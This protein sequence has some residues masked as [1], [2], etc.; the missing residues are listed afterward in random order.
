MSSSTIL[1]AGL[2]NLPFPNTRHSVGHLIVDALASRF[3][4]TLDGH[5]GRSRIVLGD[6]SVDLTLFKPKPLM[7]VTGPAVATALRHTARVPSSLIVIHDSLQHKPMSLS[8]KFGGSANGHN[9]VKSVIRALGDNPNFHRFR[10]GIGRDGDAASYVL[11][12]LSPEEI[13]YW[14]LGA[15][16]DLI[17]EKLAAIALKPPV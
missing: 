4:I 14:D 10:I 16:L 6:S 17:C 13:A 7:N 1:I 8:V 9:G 3:R 2:G 15:G 5:T 11:G 12:R